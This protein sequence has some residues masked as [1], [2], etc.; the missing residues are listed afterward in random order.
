LTLQGTVLRLFYD[1]VSPGWK[2][3]VAAGFVGGVVSLLSPRRKVALEN[4][5]MAF[6]DKDEAWRKRTLRLCYRHLA[7]SVVEYLCLVKAPEQVGNWFVSVDGE[8]ILRKL[9]KSGKGAILLTGHIGNWELFAGWLADKGYPIHAIVRPPNDADV[10]AMLEGFRAKVG[11]NTF[12]KYNI[13]LGAAKLARKGAFMAILADQDGGNE[14]IQV[15]FMGENCSTPG[16]PAAL[17]HL[18]GVPIIPVVSYRIAPYKHEIH[19]LPPLDDAPDIKNR[20]ERIKHITADANRIL[21]MMI[22]KHPEQWLWL[23]KRW[24]NRENAA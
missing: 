11:L 13:M 17:S 20:S 21:E 19:I 12:S 1:F 24:K 16:G 9:R 4:L 14:G 5:S 23:H 10:A 7:W 8:E 2:G 22:R 3:S 18:A 15:P 6:P